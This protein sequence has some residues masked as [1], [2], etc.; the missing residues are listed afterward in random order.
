MLNCVDEHRYGSGQWRE[1]ERSSYNLVDALTRH[2]AQVYPESWTAILVS[3]DNQGMWNLRSAM[4]ERQYLGQ[5]LYLRVW[6]PVQS[7]ANEYFIPSNALLCG[8]AIGRSP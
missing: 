5:Q 4:W 3:L 8:K 6:N 7:L 1:G 2:T